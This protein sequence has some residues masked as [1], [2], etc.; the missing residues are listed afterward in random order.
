MLVESGTLCGF[1][2]EGKVWE[3]DLWEMETQV[4]SLKVISLVIDPLLCVSGCRVVGQTKMPL[5]TPE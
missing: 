3:S 2:W 5:F 1:V 4:S